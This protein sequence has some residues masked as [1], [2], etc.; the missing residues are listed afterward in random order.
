MLKAPRL[1][2]NSTA[3]ATPPHRTTQPCTPDDAQTTAKDHD[4]TNNS[5][6]QTEANRQLMIETFEAW[7]DGAEPFPDTWAPDNSPNK[8]PSVCW[9][10]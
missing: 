4:M 7:R 8:K 9:V 10:F 5:V 2:A 1:S 3:A 6:A